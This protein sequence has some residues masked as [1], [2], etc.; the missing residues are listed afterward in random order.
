MFRSELTVASVTHAGNDVSF[1]G[2][3]VVNSSYVYL[4]VGVC[5]CERC[6]T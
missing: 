2:E 6:E 3:L 5:I 1:S 4:N